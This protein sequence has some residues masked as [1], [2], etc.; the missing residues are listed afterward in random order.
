MEPFQLHQVQEKGAK[1]ELAQMFVN[2]L[3]KEEVA[4]QNMNFIGYTS[5][6]VG[7]AILDMI[8]D[9]YGATLPEFDV[10][11]N[12]WVYGYESVEDGTTI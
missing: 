7:D 5:S 10:E 4:V 3:C 2:Y 1:K 8:D 9:W 6:V 12:S 11:L